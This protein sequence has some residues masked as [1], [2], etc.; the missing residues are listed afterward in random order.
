M[1]A[2][3]SN[4]TGGTQTT[5][6]GR[7][8]LSTVMSRLP[9]G[10]QILDN[11]SQL[12]P[13]YETFQ[14]LVIDR[15]QRVNDLSITR[16]QQDETEGLMGSL[17]ADK[18]YQ[19]FMYANLDLDKIKRLQDYR[20]MAGYSILNDCLEEI[21][22]ELFTEDEKNRFVLLKLQGDFS[23]AV[24]ETI[25]KEWDKYI[26]LFKFKDRGWQCGYNFMVDGEL[27]WENV[28][29]DTHPEF[30]ILGVVS[31]PT[32]LI[33]PFYRNQQ[34]DI[35]EGYAVRKPLINPKSNQQEKEQLIIL[36]PR[37]VTYIHTGRWGEGNN[38]KV[39]YIENARK[40]YKQ[41]SLIEDSIVIHRLVRAPQR[42][43]FKVDVGNL[44][45]PK[46][47]AYMKRLMQNYWSKKTYDTSTGRITN[48]Y[49]PQS[50]LDSY[51]FPKK[52]GSEGTTV[53]ALEGG[54]NLGSLD[55]LM[56]FLRQLYKSMK[57]PIGRLDPEN[58]VKDGD[59]M[60]REELRFAKFL[61]RIQKQFAAGLKD[62]FITHLK[63]RKMWE[64]FKLKEHSFELEFNLP[65][66]YMML[67]QNQIFELKYNNFNN[68]SSN[69]GVS[70]S[71]A[72][73]KYLGLTD[74]EMAQNREWKRKDAILA[75]ELA[76]IGEAGPNWKEV[77]ASG[78]GAPAE[79]GGGAPA[80]GGGGGGS[81]LPPEFGAAPEAAT[82]APAEGGTPAGGEGAA[83]PAGGAAAP[84][85]GAAPTP[86]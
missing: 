26:Q 21:C 4:R 61:Q 19:R 18:N 46:A 52:T 22:D 12:N 76:K 2:T 31:V 75:Y 34:N 47:E 74:D 3:G 5:S 80:G 11:I 79:G 17:L 53:E 60:T 36:E 23:K 6:A 86:A 56:Y 81:A 68:M 66:M 55:D 29:S 57:V 15:N 71:F 78:G 72:Q 8:F 7:S 59:A 10:V 64:N 13:K 41:L 58:V 85:G 16:Q 65:T 54:M 24:E 43:V 42:L 51:W 28:I 40:S 25:Q 67:K 39:P 69:D 45:P 1:D 62:S 20:R 27:F 14:D 83:A 38:F 63:L 70:N 33:N 84:A 44:T 77:E 35:I 32:E 82:P 49:D 48:T 37:Q 9:F 73:K 30:G 50:M